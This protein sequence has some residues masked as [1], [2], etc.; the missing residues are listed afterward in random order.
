[1]SLIAI[2][3]GNLVTMNTSTKFNATYY[4]VTGLLPGT[5]YELTVMAVSQGGD[6]FAV[7]QPSGPQNGSIGFIGTLVPCLYVLP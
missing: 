3:G 6:I 7:G 4:N 5:T 2:H 1:M